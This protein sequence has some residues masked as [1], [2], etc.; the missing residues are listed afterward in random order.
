MN[1]AQMRVWKA[2]SLDSVLFLNVLSPKKPHPGQVKWLQS[3]T[4][5]I[6][7]LVPG[8]RWGKST[9]IAM[10]HIWKCAFRVGQLREERE[11]GDPYETISVAHSA[12]Q[13]EIVFKEA[14]RLLMSKTLRPLV[15]D[16][17]AS[18]FPHIIFTN[19]SVMHCRSAHDDGKYIDGHKYMYLSID[20]AGWIPNLRHLIT[21]VILMRLAG[22]GE[23]D[24][25]GTPKGYNDLYFYFERGQ[26]GI[27]GYYSQRG[28]IY[29]NPFLPEDDIKMRDALLASGD[30]KL[31]RQVLE[32]EFVDFT[33][34][35]FT[36]DQRDNAFD[37][38]LRHHIPRLDGH[39][40]IVGWDLGR[41]TDFT[42]GCVLDITT[43]PWHLVS[44]TRL[45]RVSWEEIYA[46]IDRVAKE[47]GCSYS[48]IDATGPQGDVIEEEL[49]KRGIMVY[50]YK[51]STKAL[52]T[53]LI[54]N[55]QT[56]LDEGRHAVDFTT[57]KDEN[58]NEFPVPILQDPGTGWG[59]LRLPCVTQLMDEMGIYSLDDKDIPFTDSVMS[60]ALVTNAAYEAEGLVAPVSGGI[61]GPNSVEDA[62]APVA[63]PRIGIDADYLN[64]RMAEIA[65]ERLSSN[66]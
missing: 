1:H 23:I 20:E 37:P 43:R 66:P 54:N 18:P 36:R 52:K 22:G 50:G 5:P 61:H 19:G 32:G 64:R 47:Y 46:T 12:D 59:L 21:S 14:K 62:E 16:F 49:S 57:E 2:F 13:A 60:L 40:Y 29:D 39:R 35:A 9:V 10:K 63:G 55:L 53:E 28:S 7:V 34:L 48:V 38:A 56:A 31:R 17:R 27:S 6:N 45:N 4:Q 24:L 51:S 42:V 65:D 33:G 25:I 8:N 3:S 26:R 11:R 15:K 41:T 30:P 44:Y 58:G